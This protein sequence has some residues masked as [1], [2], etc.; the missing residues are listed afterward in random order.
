MLV[1]CQLAT[2][3]LAHLLTS[4]FRFLRLISAGARV[5][6]SG[7]HIARRQWQRCCAAPG[8]LLR[9]CAGGQVPVGLCWYVESESTMMRVSATAAIVLAVLV[10]L[11]VHTSLS[12]FLRVRV[13]TRVKAPSSPC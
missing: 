3:Q 10:G 12:L 7:K 2:C 1:N 11:R 4:A 5:I 13:R 6:P 9:D 8:M